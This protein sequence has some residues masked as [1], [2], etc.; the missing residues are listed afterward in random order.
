MTS[1][2]FHK[3]GKILKKTKTLVMNSFIM[4]K[5]RRFKSFGNMHLGAL[6]SKNQIC[7]ISIKPFSQ[8]QLSVYI[9]K[10]NKK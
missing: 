1:Q 3:L 5:K 6:I 9:S 10:N 4:I 2:L 8:Q 7:Q